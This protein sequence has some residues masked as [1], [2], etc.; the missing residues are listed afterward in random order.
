MLTVIETQSLKY[1]YTH[2]GKR[3]D[4]IYS[5]IERMYVTNILS[6]NITSCNLKP[7]QHEVLNVF[8]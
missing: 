7:I 4:P 6:R 3:S 5:D 1:N 8:T 2:F